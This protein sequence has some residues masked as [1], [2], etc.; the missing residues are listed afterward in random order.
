MLHNSGYSKLMLFSFIWT[1]LI[2]KWTMISS[3]LLVLSTWLKFT[4]LCLLHTLPTKNL[5]SNHGAQKCL[6]GKGA[7]VTHPEK[8]LD[9][10]VC[11]SV[12]LVVTVLNTEVFQFSTS[13][14]NGFKRMLQEITTKKRR[15]EIPTQLVHDNLLFYC[16]LLAFLIPKEEITDF[17]FS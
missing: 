16:N 5:Y 8:W 1:H 4:E 3:Q 12:I 6:T 15:G 17:G 14:Q 10:S 2:F 13:L 7:E 11:F 9:F